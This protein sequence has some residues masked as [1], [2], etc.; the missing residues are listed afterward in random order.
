MKFLTS[1]LILSCYTPAFGHNP[2]HQSFHHLVFAGGS[3]HAHAEW[4]K[5]PKLREEGILKVEWRNG[6]DHSAA[7]APGNFEVSLWMPDHN[8]GS[9]PTE[10]KPLTD[11]TGVPLKG[12]F[13]VKKIYFTMN[14]KWEVRIK[15]TRAGSPAE[16][17]KFAVDLGGGGHGH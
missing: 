8:H 15:L 11:S 13:E 6:S 16:T 1:L 4:V 10:I 7:D 14:G 3:Y 5:G 17:Q 9:S 2:T 12:Q